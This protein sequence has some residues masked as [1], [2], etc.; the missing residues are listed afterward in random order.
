M[1]ASTHVSPAVLAYAQS[2]FNVAKTLGVVRQVTEECKSLRGIL[3]SSPTFAEFLKGPQIPRGKKRE[4]VERVFGGKLSATLMNLF[5]VTIQRE[6]GGLIPEILEEFQNVA[7]RAE[8]IFPAYVTTA[9]ELGFQDKLKL[10]AALEEFSNCHLRINYDIRPEIKG[11]II[12]KFQ[13]SLVDASIL[14][15]LE[16]LERK[17]KGASTFTRLVA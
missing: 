17:L 1:S 5:H 15:K 6:R 7:E 9:R 8:G 13:D 14:N 4:L 3:K 11:G 10:K 12:F 2:L 16:K